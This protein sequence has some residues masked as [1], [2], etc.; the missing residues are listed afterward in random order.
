MLEVKK[1]DALVK[2]L[3]ERPALKLDIEGHADPERDLDGLKQY[4]IERKV[5]ALKLKDMIKQGQ[6][7]VPL[8]NVR[9]EPQEYEKIPNPGV[10]GGTVSQT[11]HHT[12]NGQDSSGAGDGK[13]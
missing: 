12:G 10:S 11:P 1:I 2:A 7:A 9:I 5:K 6:T 8:D 13:S 4:Q 3:H